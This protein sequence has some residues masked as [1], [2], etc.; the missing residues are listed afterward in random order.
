MST[1]DGA[2]VGVY[3]Y[4]NNGPAS[5]LYNIVILGDGYQASEMAKFDA[6]V[7]NF[8]GIFQSTAPFTEN[9]KA[10]NI[11]QVN[12]AS[13]DSGTKDPMTGASPRTYFDSTFYVGTGIQRLLT[14]DVAS[15]LAT[16]KAQVPE[17][18]L[19]IVIVN[20]PAYGGSG[21]GVAVAST[22]PYAA[23]IALHEMG[24]TAFHLADEYAFYAGP[25]PPE[26]DRGQFTGDE[27]TEAN[28]TANTTTIKWAGALT[29]AADA[30]P[31]TRSPDCSQPDTRPNPTTANYVGLFEGARYFRCGCYRP[32]FTCKMQVVNQ[33]F[34]GA[35]Q[36]A[37][38]TMLRPFSPPP[39]G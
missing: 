7:A 9:W 39:D 29:N 25:V 6:D 37:I 19:A 33:P 1:A 28:V 10:I 8:V 30:L 36:A 27:P 2:I 21:G 11:F 24:H 34:C 18:H 4:V 20:T 22:N 32:A 12:V 16:A 31:T 38:T 5:H 3:T 35:C 14:V 13:T 23:N 26:P 17:M 15:V